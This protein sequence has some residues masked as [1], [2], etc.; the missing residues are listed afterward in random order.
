M[1]VS[2]LPKKINAIPNKVI[3]LLVSDTLRKN[4]VNLDEVKEKLSTE[5]KQLL[6]ELVEELTVQVDQFIDQP[7]IDKKISD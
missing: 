6:R 3:D 4:G 5:Q 7:T 1:D 2:D